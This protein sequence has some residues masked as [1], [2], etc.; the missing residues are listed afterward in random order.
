MFVVLFSCYI[1]ILGCA[2][3]NIAMRSIDLYL[4]IYLYF[5]TSYN[6]PNWSIFIYMINGIYNQINAILRSDRAAA[7]SINFLT[8][9]VETNMYY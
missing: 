9:S 7:I 8:F 2:Q 3:I 6:Q 4:V 1:H 5:K